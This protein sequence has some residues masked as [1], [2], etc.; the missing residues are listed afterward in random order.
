MYI[1]ISTL[2][3]RN[4]SPNFLRL[5]R[6]SGPRFRPPAADP[7]GVPKNGPAR[8]PF[9]GPSNRGPIYAPRR[10][11][12]IGPRWVAKFGAPISAPPGR[13]I[14]RPGFVIRNPEG[15][16]HHLPE[17]HT[18]LPKMVRKIAKI[19]AKKTKNGPKKVQN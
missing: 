7:N 12:E 13:S 15:A 17:G 8:D 1:S 11:P 16:F 4:L 2:C 19:G 3:P 5:A 18:I 9:F 10:V 6:I 14:W